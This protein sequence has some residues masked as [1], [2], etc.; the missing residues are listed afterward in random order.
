MLDAANLQSALIYSSQKRTR[1]KEEKRERE[2]KEREER[3][4]KK[5]KDKIICPTSPCDL[6]RSSDAFFKPK[7]QQRAA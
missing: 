6:K 7:A 2:R 3:E 4:R 1:K 5:D